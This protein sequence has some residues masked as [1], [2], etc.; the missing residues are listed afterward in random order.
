MYV[1]SDIKDDIKTFNIDSIRKK[2]MIVCMSQKLEDSMQ[3][4]Y[5][6]KIYNMNTQT[7]EAEIKLKNQELIGRLLSGLY[8][9]VDGH[10]Y[11]NNNVI[12]IRY[13]LLHPGCC[14]QFSSE[15]DLFD[16]YMNIFPLGSSMRVRSNTPLNSYTCRRFAYIVQDLSLQS[17]KIIRVLPYLH[18]RMLYLNEVK[19]NTEYFYTGVT[20]Q[21]MAEQLY[22]QQLTVKYADGDP[23]LLETAFEF[24]GT[25]S[26]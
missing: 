18:A 16:L 2:I 19:K 23:E 5:T 3:S 25:K 26:Q 9:F 15:E 17:P 22:N 24:D 7:I 4:T 8:T 1:D 6:F 20:T 12:K 14:G 10:I 13:D 11:F 21:V